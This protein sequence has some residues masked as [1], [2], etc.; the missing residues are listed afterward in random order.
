[1]IL[2]FRL[3]AIIGFS[4]GAPSCGPRDGG[5]QLLVG[6]N[7]EWERPRGRS[8]A[9]PT[10]LWS[11][12]PRSFAIAGLRRNRVHLGE[13]DYV[14]SISILV[15]RRSALAGLSTI[16]VTIASRLVIVRR[17]P[18]IVTTTVS[19]SAS[20]SSAGRL[21][22]LRPRQRLTFE[23]PEGPFYIGVRG[24][25]PNAADIRFAGVNGR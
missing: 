20:A 22:V 7:K 6:S 11:S 8:F 25:N 17:R 13:R 19:F 9:S 4:P 24:D 2:R 14:I 1:M 21:L 15:A 5:L 3:P 12:L 10:G 18:S 23:A 16:C